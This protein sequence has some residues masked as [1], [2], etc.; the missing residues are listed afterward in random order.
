MSD[1]ESETSFL[2]CP[3]P[4]CAI[5]GVKSLIWK[6]WGSS[7]TK[8]PPKHHIGHSGTAVPPKNPAHGLGRSASEDTKKQVLNV[9]TGASTQGSAKKSSK[10]TPKKRPSK[11]STGT[12]PPPPP[13]LARKELLTKNTP[14]TAITVVV[15]TKDP[16]ESAP[17]AALKHNSN[18]KFATFIPIQYPIQS[19]PQ[20]SPEHNPDITAAPIITE[21]TQGPSKLS[22]NAPKSNPDVA[23]APTQGQ[24]KF[25][26]TLDEFAGHNSGPEPPHTRD[27]DEPGSRSPVP[28]KKQALDPSAGNPINHVRDTQDQQVKSKMGADPITT[29]PTEDECLT[30][31]RK[32][33]AE[34]KKDLA[35]NFFKNGLTDFG[36]GVTKMVSSLIDAG[37]LKREIAKDLSVLTLYDLVIFIGLALS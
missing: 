13:H 15:P 32:H 17:K 27:P 25:K 30:R 19:A 23:V 37:C 22:L 26:A 29:Y 34:E 33:I 24:L 4:A 8:R 11:P 20:D 21:S 2:Y 31:L 36:D 16:V 28:A 7:D 5:E 12:P 35:D 6:G 3:C 9:A 18:I 14:D 10:D 1:S